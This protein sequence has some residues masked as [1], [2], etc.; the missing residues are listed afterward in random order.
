MTRA[1]ELSEWLRWNDV[2][3]SLSFIESRLMELSQ[4]ELSRD[5]MKR[6]GR[7]MA[8]AESAI[9]RR[10]VRRQERMA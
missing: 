8:R 1:E 5:Q 4:R 7:I 10:H 6:L 3:L 9:L 2:D